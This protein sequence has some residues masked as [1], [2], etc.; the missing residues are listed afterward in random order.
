[1]DFVISLLIEITKPVGNLLSSKNGLIE[2]NSLMASFLGG[3]LIL[4]ILMFIGYMA[5]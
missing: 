4:V 1:M 5:V 3:L 2:K